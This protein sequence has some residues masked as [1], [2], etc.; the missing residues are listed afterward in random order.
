MF[1]VVDYFGICLGFTLLCERNYT[2]LPFSMIAPNDWKG[3]K[4]EIFKLGF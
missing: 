2:L 1:F 4:D 3:I